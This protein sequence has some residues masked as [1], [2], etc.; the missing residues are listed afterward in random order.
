MAV[1]I[2]NPIEVRAAGIRALNHALG[3]DIAQMFM[4]QCFGGSGD[5]TAEKQT[6]P[7]KSDAELNQFEELYKVDA[8][9][10]GMA[11]K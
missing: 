6:R 2:M 10:A 9:A 5:Y 1:D 3:A 4:K 7:P 11:W 8:E